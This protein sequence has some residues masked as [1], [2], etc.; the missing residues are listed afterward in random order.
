MIEPKL[1]QW[2]SLTWSEID[3]LNTGTGHKMHH[4]MPTSGLAEEAQNRLIEI[5]RY[6]DDIFRFRLGGKPRLW[7]FRVV[8]DFQILWFDPEHEIYPV[9]VQ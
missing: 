6:D 1:V 8:A 3:R 4:S 7:G 2:A 9:D 5:E